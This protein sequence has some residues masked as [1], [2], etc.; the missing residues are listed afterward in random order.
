MTVPAKKRPADT[1]A[2]QVLEID[3]G[4]L[5]FQ[6]VGGSPLVCNRMSQKARRE[7]L[8]PAPK[9]TQ[10]QKESTLKHNPLEEY[11]ASPYTLKDD[12]APTLIALP[13][14]AFKRAI[15]SAAIDQGGKRAQVARLC[16]VPDNYVPIYGVPQLFMAVTRQAGFVR[17]PDIRTRLILP[18]WACTLR[19]QFV[20]PI[21]KPQI[22]A[23][24]LAAAGVYI[25]VGDGR[26]EKGAL[27]FGQFRIA[28]AEDE[29]FHHVVKHGGRAVQLDG[30]REP[31]PYDDETAEMLTWFAAAARKRDFKLE[32]TVVTLEG[33]GAPP[34]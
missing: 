13:G 32:E 31:T 4:E 14:A 6:I 27:T 3:R 21:L 7:I 15:A 30:L 34:A 33:N 11:R 2:I 25:G 17:T 9:K 29:E 19:V 26:P 20:Q 18:R 28:A 22:V 8:F 10:T 23:N 12:D 24:L 16:W 5:E 1:T